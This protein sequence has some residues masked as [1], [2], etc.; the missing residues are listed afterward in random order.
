MIKNKKGTTLQF[1]WIFILVA[2]ALILAFFFSVATKQKSLSDE[3]LSLSLVQSVDTIFEMAESSEGTSQTIPLP[4]RGVSFTC[5][6]ACDCYIQTGNAR[7]SFGSNVVFAEDNIDSAQA[8]VWSLP[9]KVPFRAANI[10]YVTDPE[11]RKVVVYDNAEQMF[12]VAVVRKLQ[13]IIPDNIFLEYQTV[14]QFQTIDYDGSDLTR[15]FFVGA[16]NPFVP[17][18]LRNTNVQLVSVN[19]QTINFYDVSDSNIIPRG[20]VR[21]PEDIVWILAAI[22]AADYDMFTCGIKS[23]LNRLNNVAEIFYQRSEA[24]SEKTGNLGLVCWYP[25]EEIQQLITEDIYQLSDENLYG[26]IDKINNLRDVLKDRNDQL[27]Q[28]SCPEL[29]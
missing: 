18:G 26:V 12:S 16:I 8:V 14:G 24:L 19:P 28:Q 25:S 6:K 11:T 29:F 2:G 20:F 15:V 3:K 17:E 23:A 13:E 5:S 10:L 1:H 27:I 22:F 21:Y 7:K 9:W 4:E